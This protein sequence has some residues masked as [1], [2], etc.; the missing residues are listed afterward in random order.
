MSLIISVEQDP[1]EDDIEQEDDHRAPDHHHEGTN[2]LFMNPAGIIEYDF[3]SG[4]FER[5]CDRAHKAG[6]V[7]KI[8]ELP[9][10]AR[11]VD[12]PEDLGFLTAEPTK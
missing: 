1:R 6:A 11:D 10:L 9:S 12:V 8:L 5:H 7:L 2:A 4:S 3:G